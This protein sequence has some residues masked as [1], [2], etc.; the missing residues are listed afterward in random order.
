MNKPIFIGVIL[1]FCI[2][3]T[4]L[5]LLKH[6]PVVV[7]QA[8]GS[9]KVSPVKPEEPAIR[10]RINVKLFVGDPNSDFL[11]TEDRS[12]FYQEDLRAQIK[13]ML[14]ELLKGPTGDR[15]PEIPAGTTLRDIFVTK[16]GVVYA[17]FSSELADKHPGG[18]MAEINTVYSIVNTVTYN[19]PQIKKVQIL[20]N[21][22]AV[23]SLKG[24]IDLSR[25]LSQDLSM[26][27]SE[28]TNETNLQTQTTP[29]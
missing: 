13:E 5:F 11:E 14:E 28:N 3:G 4:I 10:R 26:V 22:Q 12:I 6:R 27:R 23:D 2:L 21:D 18:S 16:E 7:Q 8:T 24:H 19:F 29:S 20:L 1:F 17:D 9:Q 15:V 25:P